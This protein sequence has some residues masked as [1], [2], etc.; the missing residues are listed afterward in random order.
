MKTTVNKFQPVKFQWNLTLILAFVFS[1]GVVQIQASTIEG[2]PKKSPIISSSEQSLSLLSLIESEGQIEE[3]MEIE[4]WMLNPK[5]SSWCVSAEKDIPLVRWMT[6]INSQG[7]INETTTEAKLDLQKWMLIP[8][9][10]LQ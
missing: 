9:N 5:H 3:E 7:W 1:N 6:D 2:N 8:N 4:L 10:W